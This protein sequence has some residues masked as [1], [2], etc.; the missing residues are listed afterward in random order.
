MTTAK[1]APVKRRAQTPK[2]YEYD[3]LSYP[4]RAGPGVPRFVIFH[5]P[6]ED[7]MQWADV[8]RLAVDNPTG[9]QRPLQKLK[10]G[11]VARF[12]K[13]DPKNTIPTAVVIALDESAA[14]FVP[15]GPA[16]RSCGTLKIS[17]AKGGG[18]PGLII[19]GQH[20]V[21]GV[22][23]HS[24]STHLNVVAFLGGDDAERAFQ[25]VVINNSAAKVS[26]DHIKA[27]NLKFDPTKLNKRLITSAGVSM[28]VSEEKY[29]E[30]ALL[31]GSEPFKGL[32]EWATN[33][34]GYVA[35]NAL[36]SALAETKD[37]AHLLGIE[38][39]EIDVFLQ[40]WTK[41]RELRKRLWL[42][43]PQSRLLTKVSIYAI[44]VYLLD[45]MVAKLRVDDSPVDYTDVT[46]LDSLVE[47][48]VS[49]IPEEFW[50][51]EWTLKELDTAA[52]RKIVLAALGTIDSNVRYGRV[53]Y[54]D[55]AFVDPALLHGQSYG[56][57]KSQIKAKPKKS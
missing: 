30:L 5:A 4:Q 31:D 19:D 11:K 35:A 20:R 33:K 12:M 48:I 14:E 56:K 40:I 17:P 46:T 39:L 8:D 41:I 38:G 50:T 49:R 34:N 24:P 21:Y 18:R 1:K 26:K 42:P 43:F 22:A 53:W 28:G 57:P 3:A 52:G 13:A 45:S 27:L 10:I 15:A 47:R 23:G 32:I 54:D 25:F 37:R 44:T 16:P 7:I 6:T 29:E 9:A 51:T 55:V 36:E 2:T